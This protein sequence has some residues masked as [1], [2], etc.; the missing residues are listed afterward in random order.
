MREVFQISKQR[1]Q[2]FY[3]PISRE[4]RKEMVADIFNSN[5]QDYFEEILTTHKNLKLFIKWK[6]NIA[7]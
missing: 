7:K 6:F 1:L 3:F 5:N 4:I 2:R